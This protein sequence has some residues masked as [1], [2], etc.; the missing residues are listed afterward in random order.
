MPFDVERAR[1]STPCSQVVEGAGAP[2]GGIVIDTW[3]MGKL[4]IEPDDLRRIPL[5]YLTWI[6]LCD[7]QFE[8]MEDPIDETITRFRALRARASSTSPATSRSPQDMGYPAPWGVEVLSDELRNIPIEEIFDRSYETT[9]ARSPVH[10][11]R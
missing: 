1:R 10:R 2:N 11:R 6:E 5:E 7:G 8:N 3:H 4:G 9:S